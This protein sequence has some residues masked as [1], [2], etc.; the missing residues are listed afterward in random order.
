[1]F[2]SVTSV[3]VTGD[4]LTAIKKRYD[5]FCDE[6][7]FLKNSQPEAHHLVLAIGFFIFFNGAT[8]SLQNF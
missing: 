5:Y 4:E 2:E 6:L 3:S 7:G 8:N 1:M